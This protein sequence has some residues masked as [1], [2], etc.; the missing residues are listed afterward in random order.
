MELRAVNESELAGLIG[1]T[2]LVTA[3]SK[4]F[5][6]RARDAG[7][8]VDITPRAGFLEVTYPS[9]FPNTLYSYSHPLIL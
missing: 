2:R 6:G 7:V 1:G 5:T 8:R 4:A 3:Q 9:L